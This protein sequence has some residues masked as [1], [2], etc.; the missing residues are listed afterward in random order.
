MATKADADVW[1][2]MRAALWPEASVDELR[3]EVAAFFAREARQNMP[4]QVFMADYDGTPVGMLE[5]SLR[6][7]VDGCDGSPVPFIEG[8]Y[9]TPDA[10]RQGIGGALIKAAEAWALEH[11]YTE[12]ASDALLDNTISHR[13]HAALGFVE[14]ERAVRFRKSLRA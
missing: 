4:H 11:G 10:R 2:V 9:V 13:A 1:L 6:D 12:M 8:W 7:H 3:A 5:L 14:V